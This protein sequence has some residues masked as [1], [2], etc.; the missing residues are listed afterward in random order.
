M[1]RAR[2]GARGGDEVRGTEFNLGGGVGRA[3]VAN[4]VSLLV[5]DLLFLT[6]SEFWVKIRS[7]KHRTSV[8]PRLVTH[9][10]W[11]TRPQTRA[12]PPGWGLGADLGAGSTHPSPTVLLSVP[13]PA[14]F[15]ENKV[16]SNEIPES[17]NTNPFFS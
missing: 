6:E 11:G 5:A 15:C 17:I 2:D 10:G 9:G 14:Y 3:G 1:G 8:E 4:C 13:S 12:P 7:Q 16:H